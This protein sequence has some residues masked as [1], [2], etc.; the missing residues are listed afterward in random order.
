[1]KYVS[2][3][4]ET[5]GLD[6][7]KDQILEISMIVD[8]LEKPEVPLEELHFL[9]I[10]LDLD[11]IQ[12]NP[13]ALEMNSDIIKEIVLSQKEQMGYS[14]LDSSKVFTTPDSVTKLILLFFKFLGI[15]RNKGITFA[16]K[17]IAS[18]DIPFMRAFIPGFKENIIVKHRVLDPSIFFLLPTDNSSPNLSQCLERA[19]MESTVSHRA[20]D[21]ALQVIKLIRHISNSN[22]ERL[23]TKI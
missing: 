9:N 23:H 16:G 3:D 17:N 15:D 21:D 13:I 20:Y 6:P 18:F 12:G 7:E 22:K 2:I 10:L 19:S 8:D 11:R 4:I 1:M 5:T 14:A